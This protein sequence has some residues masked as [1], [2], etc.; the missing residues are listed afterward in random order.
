MGLLLS[1]THLHGENN[2]PQSA[3]YTDR[4]CFLA[5]EEHG[6]GWNFGSRMQRNLSQYNSKRGHGVFPSVSSSL[7]IKLGGFKRIILFLAMF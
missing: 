2:S 1:R 6:V 3:F 5:A 4:F 7:A